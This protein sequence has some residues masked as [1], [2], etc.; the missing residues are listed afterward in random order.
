MSRATVSMLPVSERS[1]A[2]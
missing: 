1:Q 2:V